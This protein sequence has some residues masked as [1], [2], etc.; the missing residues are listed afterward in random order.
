MDEA[1]EQSSES[2]RRRWP[3]FIVIGLLVFAVGLRLA[4]PRIL[5][6]ALESVLSNLLAAHLDIEDVRLTLY[7]GVIAVGAELHSQETGAL[8]ARADSIVLDVDWQALASG[9]LVA[10]HVALVGPELVFAFDEEDRFNWDGVGGPAKEPDPA[11]TVEADPAGAFRIGI[12]QFEFGAGKLSFIDETTGGLPN[13]RLL[14]GAST[15]SGIE[16]FRDEPGGALRWALASA[17]ASEWTFGIAPDEG[18]HIDF[19]LQANAGPITHEQI[20]FELSLSREDGV[21][22]RIEA[23]VRPTPLEVDAKFSWRQLRSRDAL[24]YLADIGMD[25][26]GG[27][28]HGDFDVALSFAPG[29]DRGIR[30]RGSATHE[31][32]DLDIVGDSPAHIGVKRIYVEVAELR[33]PIPEEPVEPAPMILVH[34][35]SIEVIDPVLEVTLAG[36]GDPPKASGE[37]LEETT[38]EPTSEPTRLDLRIDRVSLQGG[39]V[40]WSDPETGTAQQNTVTLEGEDLRWP[41]LY[42]EAIRLRIGG[43]APDPV[44]FDGSGSGDTAQA[45][46]QARR[47]PLPDWNP[48]IAHYTDYS[49]SRGTLSAEGTFSVKGDAYNLP[50]VITF[51]GLQAKSQDGHFQKTFG[52]PISLAIPLL[53]DSSGAIRL[54]VPVSGSFSRGTHV[55]LATIITVALREAT[56]NALSN[57]VTAPVNMAGSALRRVGEVFMLGLGEAAFDAGEHTL[58]IDAKAVLQSAATL[59][60]STK[61]KR[62]ELVPEL[63]ADDLRAFDIDPGDIGALDTLKS[64]GRTLFG[65]KQASTNEVRARLTPLADRRSAAVENYLVENCGFPRGRIIK[66]AWD[67]KIAD[68]IP[69]VLLRLKGKK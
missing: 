61:T 20:P 18:E 33:V 11:P 2:T 54:E 59:V 42:G 64:V 45:T 53:S 62:I 44:R 63:V 31:A 19:V 3:F 60:A 13:L 51:R 22:I 35:A 69:R 52:M 32:L 25:V 21:E 67:G 58:P 8:L 17:D 56:G 1:S 30:I 6:F 14:L 47:V 37:Y 26:K 65:G 50:L 16:L 40:H 46:F 41:H 10:E 38:P 34:L 29:P 9:S 36:A 4:L 5:E 28:S 43:L 7:E 12:E 55:D 15:F 48:I 57:T 49:V 39:R 27:A 68:G 66:T 23:T 24:G